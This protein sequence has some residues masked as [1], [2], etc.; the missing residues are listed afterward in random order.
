MG[1]LCCI[2]GGAKGVFVN[3][4]TMEP[5]LTGRHP[6]ADSWPISLEW[7]LDIG[8]SFPYIQALD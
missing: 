2:A 3:A 1:S 5:M 4:A 6:I 7:G 8:G